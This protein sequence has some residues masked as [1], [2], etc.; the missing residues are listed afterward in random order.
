MRKIV[1]LRFVLRTQPFVKC[2]TVRCGIW[3]RTAIDADTKLCVTFHVGDRGEYSALAFMW[4]CASRIIG[5][6]QITTDAHNLAE[7]ETRDSP[8]TCIGCDMKT[9]SG[10]PDAAHVSTPFV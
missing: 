7:P 4:D 8:K 10:V 9:V 2:S 6:P 5:R 3:T 1:R